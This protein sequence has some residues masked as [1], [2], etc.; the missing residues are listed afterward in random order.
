MSGS[1][2]FIFTPLPAF[3]PLQNSASPFKLI[4]T[5]SLLLG[6]HNHSIYLKMIL[7]LF[8]LISRFFSV[9]DENHLLLTRQLLYKYFF[10]YCGK[11]FWAFLRKIKT[12]ISDH[13]YF[14]YLFDILLCV[15]I[16]IYF[17][18]CLSIFLPVSLSIYLSTCLFF[19]NLSLFTCLFIYV[20]ISVY[21]SVY[22]SGYLSIRSEQLALC[23]F[24]S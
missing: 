16:P 14:F 17:F 1:L 5:Q 11:R 21:L 12:F 22:L 8:P 24:F 13:N 23:T 19:F 6:L 9:M 7:I 10:L 15:S 2:L 18:T 4:F 3:S 20:F